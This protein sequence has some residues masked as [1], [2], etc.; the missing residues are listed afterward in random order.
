M[1]ALDRMRFRM[2]RYRLSPQLGFVHIPKAGGTGLWSD[3]D[4]WL[5][6]LRMVGGW[7]RSQ[8]GAFTAFDSFAPKFRASIYISPEEMSADADIIAGH[9]AVSTLRTRYPQALLMT[10]LREPMSRLLS[11]WYYLRNYTD[12]VLADY[13]EWGANLALSRRS[14][15]EFI[16]APAV[17]CFTDNVAIRMLLWPSDRIPLAG[18]ISKDDD[19]A[20][21]DEA[22]HQ[23]ASLD[24][25]D[26][27]EN[28]AM[29][30]GLAR[31][32]REQYGWNFWARVRSLIP[33]R[34]KTLGRNEAKA[35]IYGELRP[36][37]D[38]LDE[39]TREI[40]ASH[41]RLDQMLW[42]EV[43]MRVM[44][45]VDLGKLGVDTFERTVERYA[46]LLVEAGAREP[47]A[48]PAE[49]F[50]SPKVLSSM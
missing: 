29:Q 40:M 24:H 41:T 44:P 32:L 7:D 3:L 23:V 6:P 25:I 16:A 27:L 46:K 13:G 1:N 43:A 28:P 11:L 21:L 5:R 35:P 50:S 8:V 15:R 34:A 36:M 45:G 39:R 48:T 31:W 9:F 10:I 19:D 12:E 22:L 4:A 20:L 18:F 49:R 26:V 14:L 30:D 2:T 38:E 42:H 37:S 17:A 33:D 47:S